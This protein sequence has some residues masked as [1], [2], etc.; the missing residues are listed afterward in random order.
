[1]SGLICAFFLL[2]VLPFSYNEVKK[3]PRVHEILKDRYAPA[4]A[5]TLCGTTTAALDFGLQLRIASPT[6][7]CCRTH[8]RTHAHTR[9]FLLL[10][11]A[12]Q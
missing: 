3:R 2:V 9:T 8:T 5:L 11:G 7:V 12:I 6:R 1:M 10:L 4:A